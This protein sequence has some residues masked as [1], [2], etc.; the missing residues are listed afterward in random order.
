MNTLIEQDPSTQSEDKTRENRLKRNISPLWPDWF[1]EEQELAWTEYLNSPSPRRKDEYWRFSNLKAL[2]LSQFVA[3]QSTTQ[4]DTLVQRSKCLLP[5]S[6]RVVFG[7]DD[8][9][10]SQCGSL[11]AGVVIKSLP[12]AAK[13]D[14][15]LFRSFFMR[16]PVELGSHK[17]AALH[18]SQ[19]R[20]GV[21]VYIPPG[22]KLETPIEIFSWVCGT[23]TAIYPHTLVVCGENSE[24]TVIDHFLSADDKP[25]FACGVHDLHLEKNSKLHYASVQEWSPTSLSLHLHSTVVAEGADCTAMQIN[26]GG[27][28]VRG[29]SLSRMTGENAR[30]VMLSLN[31]VD[32][33]REIDQRT[34]Q[35]HD[36]PGA[37]SD[38]L[39]HNSLDNKARTIFSGLIKV[40][41]GAH[42][43]DAYQ[44]VRNLILSDESEANSMPGLEIL[45]D[46]VRCTHGATS[47][48]INQDEVFY[49]QA[50]GI[51]ETTARRL[52][53]LGFF[54]ELL[55]RFENEALKEA[56]AD[57]LSR[58]LAV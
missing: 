4:A 18:R 27:R 47:G 54:R 38:L 52:I 13:E 14:S 22:V 56:I 16:Q 35:C 17:F 7:N 39:Y 33:E 48:E 57:R 6:V 23:N 3:A 53:V 43:T 30:S 8:M 40:A 58:R 19:I 20:G 36:A 11:P 25:A 34:L 49:M 26:L 21:L 41:E 32:G 37:T 31:P 46:N 2:D 10:L 42:R 44:K 50:R 24:A 28:F 1:G 55:D 9:L 45:A 29:E 12:V 5:N 51:P 15:D